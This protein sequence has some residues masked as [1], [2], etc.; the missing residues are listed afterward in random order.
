MEKKIKRKFKKNHK[1]CILVSSCYTS[2]TI[3]IHLEYKYI[4]TDNDYFILW[5]NNNAL[6]NLNKNKFRTVDDYYNDF[7]VQ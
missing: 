6:V 2:D 1:Y 3:L 5:Y 7:S 4:Y